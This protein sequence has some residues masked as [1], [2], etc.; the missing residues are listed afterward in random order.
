MYCLIGRTT[1][2]PLSYKGRVIVHDDKAEMEYLFPN[3]RVVKLPAV[4]GEDL[5]MALKFHPDMDTV[6]FPL[7]E[8]MYQFRK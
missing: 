1:N 2:E 8:H 4:Y 3:N 5:T 6:K 7:A